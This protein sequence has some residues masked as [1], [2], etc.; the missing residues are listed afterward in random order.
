MLLI[1]DFVLTM[2]NRIDSLT[3]HRPITYTTFAIMMQHNL[4]IK[5][6]LDVTALTNY[7]WFVDEGYLANPY[8]RGA[9]F[10]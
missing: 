2:S 9:I 8:V 1:F 10:F 4:C 5:C 6:N 7:L 3:N